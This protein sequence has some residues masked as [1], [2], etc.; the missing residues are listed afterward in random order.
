MDFDKLRVGMPVKH[1]A[2]G[3]F[4]PCG[5]IEAIGYDW[6]VVRFSTGYAQLLDHDDELQ[7]WN[8]EDPDDH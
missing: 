1:T 6:V 4:H 3:R 2:S 5:R 7:A 8:G